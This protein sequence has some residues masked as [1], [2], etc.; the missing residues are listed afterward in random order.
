MKWFVIELITV[1][2]FP[3]Q[4]FPKAI[5]VADLSA[6]RLSDPETVAHKSS[7]AV[8]VRLTCEFILQA[9]LCAIWKISIRLESIPEI[10]L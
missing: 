8:G 7:Y 4:S 10:V 3:L 6:Q 9:S 5:V 1:S 2:D